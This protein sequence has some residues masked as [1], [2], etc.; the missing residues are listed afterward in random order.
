[1]GLLYYKKILWFVL[2]L[3]LMIS[4]PLGYTGFKGSSGSFPSNYVARL[5][6]LNGTRQVV[7]G[8]EYYQLGYFSFG[9]VFRV[10]FIVQNFL[11][12]PLNA[13]IRVMQDRSPHELIL[14]SEINYFIV[15][16]RSWIRVTVSFIVV[17][18]ANDTTM[19]NTGVFIWVESSDG[20][21]SPSIVLLAY[22]GPSH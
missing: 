13:T 11:N 8:K 21:V 7:N 4:F 2:F 10:D 22:V 14:I 19:Q 6:C 12:S 20:A 3:V 17:Q 18:S 16:P 9:S 1:M 5:V 15:K